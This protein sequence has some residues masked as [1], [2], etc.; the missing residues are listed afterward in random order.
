MGNEEHYHKLERMYLAA[1]INAFY[2]PS[3]SISRGQAVIQT[4]VIPE[5]FHAAGALHGSVYFKLLDD[6]AFFAA[7]SL[8]EDFFLLT[9]SFNLYLTRPVTEGVLIAT[10]Q[11]VSHSSNYLVAE[12]L[13]AVNNKEVARGSGSFLRSRIRLVDV[14][15]YK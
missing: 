4:R 9:V 11:V 13:L 15:S 7:N 5:Y 2:Q 3:I 14:D 1:P 10:G 8:V 6:A 12:S